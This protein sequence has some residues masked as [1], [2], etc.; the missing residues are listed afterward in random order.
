MGVT[1]R[2]IASYINLLKKENKIVRV[3]GKK[4]GYWKILDTKDK[5]EQN[6]IE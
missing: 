4:H 2:T 6:E 3:N 5:K 1:S